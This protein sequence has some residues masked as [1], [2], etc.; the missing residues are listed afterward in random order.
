MVLI[1]LIIVMSVPNMVF[2]QTESRTENFFKTFSEDNYHMKAKTTESGMD[3]IIETF[4]Q[5]DRSATI[6][7]RDSESS[8][9]I[10]KDNKMYMVMDYAKLVIVTSGTPGVETRTLQIENSKFT[11]TG[12]EEFNGKNLPYDEFLGEEDIKARYFYD[13][14]KLVGLRNVLP[15]SQTYDITILELDQIIPNGTFDIPSD[16][17]I[18]DMT[19]Y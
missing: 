18:Q 1:A 3:V 14:D 4:I 16:Y 10:Q 5:G 9:V 2:A 8:R 13:G 7:T 17:E 11:G 19:E 15:D 6:M 12:T